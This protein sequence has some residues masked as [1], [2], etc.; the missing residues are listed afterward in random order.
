[1]SCPVDAY[2]SFDAESLSLNT[3]TEMQSDSGVRFNNEVDFRSL[4]IENIDLLF[5]KYKRYG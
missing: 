5:P 4:S 3:I 2:H 1:M